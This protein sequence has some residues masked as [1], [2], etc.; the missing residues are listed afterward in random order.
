MVAHTTN[1]CYAREGEV[2]DVVGQG[3]SDRSFDGVA[4][5]CIEVFRDHIAGIVDHVNVVAKASAQNISTQTSVEA[6]VGAV[7]DEGIGQDVASPIDGGV[8][9][10]CEVFHVVTQSESGGA[11]D[12]VDSFALQF[13]DPVEAVVHQIGI[14]ALAATHA[15]HASAAIQK[16]VAAATDQG[17]VTANAAQDVVSIVAREGIGQVVTRA[18]KGCRALE[19]EVFDVVAQDDADGAFDQIAALTCPFVDHIVA[20]VHHI[21][22]VAQ[23]TAHAVSASAAI[24]TVIPSHCGQGVVASAAHQGVA[25]V[26]ACKGVGQV[27]AGTVNGGTACEGEV[28]D[29]VAQGESGGALDRVGALTCHFVDHIEAVVHH[30]GV[31]AYATAQA[32]HSCATVQAVVTSPGCQGVVACPTRQRIMAMT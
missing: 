14:V 4:V 26:V 9:C 29:V 20:V 27:V 28:L 31:V 8:A 12:Q 30:I 32:I 25:A 1:G 10:E 23:A 15:V 24:Q 19:G 5:A 11:F 7:A 16:I 18:V 13:G 2:L 6:V 21:G 17:V 3:V 22:V